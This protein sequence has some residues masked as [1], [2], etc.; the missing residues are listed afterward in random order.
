MTKFL[1]FLNESNL[2]SDKVEEFLVAIITGKKKF[3]YCAQYS[4][5]EPFDDGGEG[6]FFDCIKNAEK[7]A[8]KN[9]DEDVFGFVE[10]AGAQVGDIF[11]K[12]DP[13]KNK[14]SLE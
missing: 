4:D 3:E 6:D 7:I 10:L 13:K 14:W 11:L 12:F 2:K 8:S 9:A 5:S 1:D